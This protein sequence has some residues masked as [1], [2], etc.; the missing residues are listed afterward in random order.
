MKVERR[1]KDVTLQAGYAW[2]KMMDDKSAA[3]AL[4]GDAGGAYG[5]QNGHCPS[6][7]YSRSSYDVGQ[8]FV[9]SALYNLPFGEGEYVGSKSPVVIRKIIS[10]FQ[11][12]GIGTLQGGF[13]FSIAAADNLSVNEANSLRANEVSNPDPSGFVRNIN[14]WFNPAAFANPAPGYFGNSSRNVIRGPGI[15][16]LDMSLLKNLTVERLNIQL[17]F[18]SFNV[19]NHPEFGLPNNSVTSSALGTITSTNSYVT[20]RE[21]QAAIRITF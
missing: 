14:H 8:R 1:A 17:R 11:L 10:G 16:N 4:S 9:I 18:E 13:P 15:S 5:F 19:L 21:N 3:A 6:C 7:D 20:A 2:S 12:N